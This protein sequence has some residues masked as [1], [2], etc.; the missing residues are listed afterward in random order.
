MIRPSN[1]ASRCAEWVWMLAIG[2]RKLALPVPDGAAPGL[3][4][5]GAGELPAT[6]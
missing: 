4:R 6:K 1:C 3:R 5:S 2:T